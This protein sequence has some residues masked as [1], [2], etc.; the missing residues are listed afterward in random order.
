MTR[1]DSI[2]NRTG[3][4]LDAIVQAVPDVD[5]CGYVSNAH[6]AQ[7]TILNLNDHSIS[8]LQSGDLAGLSALEELWLSE[9]QL[10]VLPADIFSGLSTLQMLRLHDNLFTALPADVFSGLA[11]LEVLS[12]RNNQLESLP[13]NVFA[14]LPELRLLYLSGNRLSV[15]PDGILSG[16]SKLE[17]I[18]LYSN[19]IASLPA[20]TFSGLSS[21]QDIVLYGND[22]TSLP[23]G[24]FSGLSSLRTLWL[25][26]NE[27]ASL[28]PDVFAGLSSL[29]ILRLSENELTS[30]PAGVFSG[31]SA[32]QR[33]ALNVN[34]LTTLPDGSFA[35][36]TN[37]REVN[38]ERNAVDPLRFSVS[39]EKAGNNQFKAVAPVGAPFV[40]AIPVSASSSGTIEGDVER[41]TIPAG[42]V[43][44]APVGVSRVPDT[45]EAVTVDIGTLPSLTAQHNGY[46]LVKDTSLPLPVLPTLVAADA[47]LSGLSLSHGT[48]DPVFASDT[49]SYTAPVPHAVASI[50]VNVTPRIS[51]ATL[52]YFDAD[53]RELAD[54]D[55][56]TAGHQANLDVGDNTV[57]VKVTSQ[58]ETATRT[59]VI[60]VTRAGAGIICS[61]HGSSG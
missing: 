41:V 23:A 7:I 44:S 60:V 19:R 32:L 8:S 17:L 38:L 40:L 33:L 55:A 13:D 36:L 9:N 15:L 21:L 26:R 43:E 39:L 12:V 56:G 46:V 14:G 4:I 54:A 10:T 18:W 57:K 58:D 51:Q 53:D 1:E 30:L 11:A 35:G 25:G 37:L 20:D 52:A 5:S 24:V 31:L 22:L 6:L 47:A 28:P 3:E 29:V 50:T 49:T 59:Y 61:P 42:A 48:L 34:R 16:L 45:S 2:C 27:L